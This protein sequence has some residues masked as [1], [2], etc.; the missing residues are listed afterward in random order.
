MVL[1]A[2]GNTLVTAVVRASTGNHS[3]GKNSSARS[4]LVSDRKVTTQTPYGPVD[5]ELT[6]C[7]GPQCATSG[8]TKYMVGWFQISP[9]GQEI[10]V[11][12]RNPDPMDFCS[13]TCLYKGVSLMT[14]N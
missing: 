7:D 4:S 11:M 6:S 3:S 8:Q 2:S 5:V 13:L 10:S 1:T 14:G 12:G 9:R